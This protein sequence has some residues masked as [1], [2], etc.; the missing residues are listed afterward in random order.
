MSKAVARFQTKKCNGQTAGN[1][2]DSK[3]HN[4]GSPKKKG[5]GPKKTKKN[6]EIRAREVTEKTGFGKRLG[7]GPASGGNV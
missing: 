7:V 6:L 1:R 3:R 5:N 2:G 4:P